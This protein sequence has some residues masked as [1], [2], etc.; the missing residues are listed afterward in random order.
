MDDPSLVREIQRQQEL[1]HD[2]RDLRQI[3]GRPAIQKI[4]KSGALDIFHDDERVG[5]VF[6]V[7]VHAD[8]VRMQQPAGRSRFILESRHRLLDQIGVD[9]VL[10]YGLDRHCALDAGIERLVN[11]PHRALAK[12]AVDAVFAYGGGVSHG[13]PLVH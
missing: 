10:A 9:Q 3:E 13:C 5:V 8:D 2:R 4:A 12:H 1:S 11:D 6:A 7:L